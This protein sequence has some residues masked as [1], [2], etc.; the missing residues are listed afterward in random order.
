MLNVLDFVPSL[1]ELLGELDNFMGIARRHA[2]PSSDILLLVSNHL[3][4]ILELVVDTLGFVSL[5]SKGTRGGNGD[6]RGLREHGMNVLSRC[7]EH[8]LALLL[9]VELLSQLFGSELSD[10][11]RLGGGR[12]RRRA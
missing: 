8:F 3:E 12:G 10:G 7:H 1:M 2:Q 5:D 4:G 11:G 6:I 9:L